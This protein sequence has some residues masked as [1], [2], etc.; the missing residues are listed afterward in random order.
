[1][2]LSA[3]SMKGQGKIFFLNKSQY[4]QDKS[5]VFVMAVKKELFFR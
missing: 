1:M 3:A 4:R 5:P 2:A